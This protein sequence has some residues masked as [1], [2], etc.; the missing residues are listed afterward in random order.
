MAAVSPIY[1][2]GAG[3]EL[4]ISVYD[5]EKLTGIYQI[6]QGG[7]LAFPLISS[8]DAAG[9]TPDQLAAA[10]TN[11]LGQ[12]YIKDPRVTVDVKTY[13]PFFI[14]GEVERPGRYPTLAGTT[15]L[16]A[17]AT[18]GGPT[19]RADTKHVFLRRG[20]GPETLVT[21]DTDL[22]I[23]PGDIIRVGERYF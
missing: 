12:G 8:I 23:L 4:A 9:L 13:R 6:G 2:L 18:A 17:I 11:A 15:V 7:R 5:E 1:P 20:D 22:L 19:Y 21:L 10:L 3:D 16:R 14:S